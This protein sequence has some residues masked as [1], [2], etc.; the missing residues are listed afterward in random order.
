[1]EQNK[2]GRGIDEETVSLTIADMAEELK[3]HSIENG[4]LDE[5]GD[6]VTGAILDLVSA[7]EG[8]DV[9]MTIT[10]SAQVRDDLV[11]T[12]GH[13]FSRI[14]EKEDEHHAVRAISKVM[15]RQLVNGMLGGIVEGLSKE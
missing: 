6:E 8:N 1:M 15:T 2:N 14:E 5:S 12:G 10:M 9:D 11:W 3:E 13:S 4:G 7:M